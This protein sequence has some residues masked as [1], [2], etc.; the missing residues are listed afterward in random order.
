MDQKSKLKTSIAFLGCCR[1]NKV[2]VKRTFA[3]LQSTS[4]MPL[5][6]WADI[7][8]PLPE[9]LLDFTRCEKKRSSNG[10]ILFMIKKLAPRIEKKTLIEL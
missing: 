5:D 1:P 4:L 8:V 3:Q 10:M 9:R 7:V 2:L 6:G